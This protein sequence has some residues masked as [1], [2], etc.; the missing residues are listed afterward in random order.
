MIRTIQRF[1]PVRTQHR[2]VNPPFHLRLIQ[3]SQTFCAARSKKPLT[4]QDPLDRDQ[5]PDSKKL[6][7]DI[8]RVHMERRCLRIPRV[9]ST[10]KIPFVEPPLLRQT[11]RLAPRYIAQVRVHRHKGEQDVPA[12][13]RHGDAVSDHA[14]ALLG[15]GEVVQWAETEHDVERGV[16]GFEVGV[17]RDGEGV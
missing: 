5:V 10:L 17:L 13:F 9:L 7:Q 4:T 15:A 2:N 1:H 12:R 8:R 16:G 3:S 11:R 6:F 14:G